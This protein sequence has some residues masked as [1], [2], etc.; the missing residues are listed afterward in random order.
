M[1]RLPRPSAA[2]TAPTSSSAAPPTTAP[3]TRCCRR[4][5]RRTSRVR[6]GGERHQLVLGNVPAGQRPLQGVLDLPPSLED[7]RGDLVPH[8]HEVGQRHRRRWPRRSPAGAAGT[9]AAPPTSRR[10]TRPGSGPARPRP[11]RRSWRPG[12]RTARWRAPRRRAAPTFPYDLPRGAADGAEHAH[13]VVL[14]VVDQ[15]R[16]QR[17]HVRVVLGEVPLDRRRAVQRGE[18]AGAV[19]GPEQRA[20]EGAVRVRQRDHHRG[21][22]R[23]DVQRV[24]V[25]REVPAQRRDRQLLVAVVEEVHAL[26]QQPV[27]QQLPAH[28]GAGAVGAQH[29]R[30][31][32]RDRALRGLEAQRA[33]GRVEPDQPVVEDDPH[34][35]QRGGLVQQG[36]VQRTPADRVDRPVAGRAVRLELL[37]ALDRVDHPAAH[38][39]R[40]G[41]HLLGQPD[42]AQRVQ[43]PLGERQVDRATALGGA[44]ARVGAAL[45]EGHRVAAPGQEAGAPGS[46]PARRR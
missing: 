45:V 23:P 31:L 27:R 3:S 34:S 20:G 22:A 10:R 2:P 15:V 21:A 43:A 19:V 18:A 32:R 33:V 17:E 39:Q 1:P 37:L 4:T 11:R 26:V 35:G 8:L 25:E 30:R 40:V 29:D 7:R 6:G 42:A 16:G 41:H 24:R 28:R 38:R 9:A 12:R 36:V 13:R 5:R 14:V 46:R 44:G